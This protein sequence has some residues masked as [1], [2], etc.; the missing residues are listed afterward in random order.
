LNA[1]TP[2]LH[3]TI[4]TPEADFSLVEFLRHV[5]VRDLRLG[6]CTDRASLFALHWTANYR[7]LLSGII[8]PQR[9]MLMFSKAG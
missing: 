5:A 8:S 9:G 6:H 2:T 7:S 3:A 4:A 1:T